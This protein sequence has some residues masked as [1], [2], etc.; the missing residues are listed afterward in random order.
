MSKVFVPLVQQYV[1][2]PPVWTD[3]GH[4]S[5]RHPLSSVIFPLFPRPQKLYA[6]SPVPVYVGHPVQRHFHSVVGILSS[7]SC[8][9]ADLVLSPRARC[10][11]VGAD[12]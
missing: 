2:V 3:T 8:A 10:D 12:D 5:H 4:R 6:V 1:S 9:E 7:L 11:M